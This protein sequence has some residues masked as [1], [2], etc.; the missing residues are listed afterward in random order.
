MM[1]RAEFSFRLFTLL[2]VQFVNWKKVGYRKDEPSRVYLIKE[3][4]RT[5]TE[6]SQPIE[7]D[8]RYI[9]Q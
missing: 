1:S 7:R 6:C 5:G 3:I 2:N 8:C 9:P 4:N